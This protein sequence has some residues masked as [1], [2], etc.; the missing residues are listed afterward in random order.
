MKKTF[1]VLLILA[2]MV[3]CKK[4]DAIQEVVVTPLSVECYSG[5]T[6]T[7]RVSNVNTFSVST[8]DSCVAVPLG[9][10]LEN[11]KDSFFIKACVVGETYIKI[12]ANE[13]VKYVS[14]FVLPRITSFEDVYTLWGKS[15]QEVQSVV[16][17]KPMQTKTDR[18]Y[19]ALTD[20]KK[21]YASYEFS[22]KGLKQ[23]YVYPEDYAEIYYNYLR[24]RYYIETIDNYSC[25]F[26]NHFDL[27]R[28][29]LK[30]HF[31][32]NTMFTDDPFWFAQYLPF[33]PTDPYGLN[34]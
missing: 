30:V 14:V 20:D 16:P 24:E 31:E 8:A 2:A 18:L 11:R 22:T 17:A 6:V 10:D 9:D 4:T 5:D 19:Y 28:A 15:L 27:N 23:I 29:T 13:Q 1:L 34:N 7:I 12:V 26:Y 3:S 21:T 33:D 25:N 32:L